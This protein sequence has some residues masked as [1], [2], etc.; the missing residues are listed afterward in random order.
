MLGVDDLIREIEEANLSAK[1]MMALIHRLLDKEFSTPRGMRENELRIKA[2]VLMADSILTKHF[3]TEG[4][5]TV[6]GKLC[7]LFIKRHPE[8]Q[9]QAQ[10]SLGYIG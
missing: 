1:E 8:L 3:S 5:L 4:H 9:V 6:L 10:E 2:F 7:E